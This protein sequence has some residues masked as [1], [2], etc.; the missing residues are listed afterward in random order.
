[1]V[2][3]AQFTC[4]DVLSAPLKTERFVLEDSEIHRPTLVNNYSLAVAK[5]S[6][7]PMLC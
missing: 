3:G 2:P 4:L 7:L 5:C 6:Q 1:M